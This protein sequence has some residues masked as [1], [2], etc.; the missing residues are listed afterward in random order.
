MGNSVAVP[1]S[2]GFGVGGEVNLSYL[3]DKL[4]CPAEPLYS[5]QESHEASIY[6]Y[7]EWTALKEKIHPSMLEIIQRIQP[8][9]LCK[10]VDSPTFRTAFFANCQ[11]AAIAD[12]LQKVLTDSSQTL[13]V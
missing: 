10:M 7:D 1:F 11:D 2:K 8:D 9:Y 12:Y 13:S 4:L 3:F 6:Y 5:S